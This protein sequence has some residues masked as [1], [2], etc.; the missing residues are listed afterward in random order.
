MSKVNFKDY[1][2]KFIKAPEQEQ[3]HTWF[4]VALGTKTLSV[5]EELNE[6][7]LEHVFE[8]IT[9]T[10]TAIL[11]NPKRGEN[12]ITEKVI[13]NLDKFR[14]FADI[15]FGVNLFEKYELPS[16]PDLLKAWMSDLVFLYDRVIEEIYGSGF[17][18]DRVLAVRLPYKIHIIYP[19]VIVNK[20]IGNFLSDKFAAKLR[21]DER[22]KGILTK[23]EKIIDK[24]VYSTGLR[25][26]GMHKS[27]MGKKEKMEH[28]WRVH[29]NIFGE[30]SYTHCYRFVHPRTFDVLATTS[31]MFSNASIRAKK[32]EEYT[33]PLDE[34]LF[35]TLIKGKG[36]ATS[37]IGRAR[38]V[39]NNVSST[40]SLL[41]ERSR[42]LH[43]NSLFDGDDD[44]SATRFIGGNVGS[45]SSSSSSSSRIFHTNDRVEVDAVD[46]VYP[47]DPIDPVDPDND[48]EYT[49]Y[50][51]FA[52]KLSVAEINR[53]LPLT[54]KFLVKQYNHIIKVDKIVL[55]ETID[56]RG[57]MNESLHRTLI[58]PL[59]T[60]ECHLAGRMHTG[61][62]QYLV[63]DKNGSRQKCHD[64]SRRG[65]NSPIK[66]IKPG[67]LP[68]AVKNELYTIDIIKGDFLMK[69][70]RNHSAPS[71]AEKANV[72]VEVVN[73]VRNY[74][75]RNDLLVDENTI[76]FNHTGAYVRLM[77]LYCELCKCKHDDPETFFQALKSGE[78]VLHC[79]KNLTVG[80][81]Y[82]NPPLFLDAESRQFLFSDIATAPV[83]V[84]DVGNYGEYTGDVPIDFQEEPI[85]EDEELNHLIFESLANTTWPIVKVIHHLGKYHFNCTIGGE[86][87]SFKKHRWV[88][89]S[90][91][92]ITYFI[93]ENVA[94]YYRQVRDFYRENTEN[95]E[96]R[97]KRVSHLQKIIDKLTN[98]NQ[99]AEIL[100][101]AKTYFYEKDYYAVDNTNLHFEDRLDDQRH[102][103]CFSNGVKDLDNDIF[104]DG[105]PYDFITMTVGFD[106]PS[107]SNPEK[108]KT[109]L[110]FFEDI[111]PDEEERDYLLL[112]LSS[113]L[114]GMTKEETFHIF[115]GAAANGKS[116]LRD[117]IMAMLGE[118]FES[119]PANLLTKE[120]P[121]SSSPQPEMVKLKGKR[122]VFGSEPEAGQKINTGFM[123]FLTGNDPLK[124][125][126]CHSNDLVEF[127]P[128][129]K[130]ILLCNDLPL[131]DSNDS[132][133]W[134]RARIIEY[135]VTFMDKPRPGNRYEKKINENLKT[136]IQ[137]C[138][139]ECMLY[140]L[141]IFKRFKILD[142]LRPTKKVN[143]MVD[144]H[145]KR[146]NTV[147]QFLVEN[148]EESVGHG[149]LLVD[150]YQKYLQWMRSEM[151]G[152]QPL[153]KSKVI[154]ELM[155]MKDID[156]IKHCRVKG[157]KGGGQHGIRNRKLIDRENEDD[158]VPDNEVDALSDGR[159]GD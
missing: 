112:F 130:L 105:S 157:R 9:K 126:L 149:I 42:K 5:P 27:T 98:T 150:F 116:L 3:T 87:F 18:E 91:S 100:K 107:E 82:P 37:S 127:H 125:R 81:T 121:S 32:S 39:N 155:R 4:S 122:A 58:I 29:E 64:C 40:S 45:S 113:L 48:N 142:R 15:D 59:D 77:D 79:K 53:K 108:R 54:I 109:V 60:K 103:L 16:E 86:W 110:Q 132:G 104:R 20:A 89:N 128:H 55:L 106:Y 90:E 50:G 41:L 7:F 34:T 135:P 115:T 70:P 63:L 71:D 83:S 36:K 49:E 101:E 10:P 75:P 93:S 23:D 33:T 51:T 156:Y 123:K 30:N 44:F 147:A 43:V 74:F 73:R 2:S 13:K 159:P 1:M 12:S 22:F 65:V 111:Q 67:R 66:P 28:E 134:R 138:K 26:V 85:F 84:G 131:M 151:P 118:Y 96:L 56:D 38:L 46:P 62:H 76:V 148:T 8:Y 139:E 14:M 24:S 78:M 119:I 19:S 136:T 124:A 120:R 72:M 144:A 57:T 61:N 114:H 137:E 141:E 154:D 146:S 129:Y 6:E 21:D 145:K 143:R 68:L 153:I 11:E 99:K 152:E 133:T 140:F 97:T 102:L 35:R 25:M 95:P 92:A 94:R 47:I 117:L 80:K 17:T 52:G 158:I 31:S 88:R 69:N